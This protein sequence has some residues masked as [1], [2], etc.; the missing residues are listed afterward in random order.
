M[1]QYFNKYG[2]CFEDRQYKDK[3]STKMLNSPT[4]L[5]GKKH[6]PTNKCS[7]L[8]LI[9][10]SKLYGEKRPDRLNSRE[11]QKQDPSTVS[12][13]GSGQF[14]N[15]D[16]VLGYGPRFQ[17]GSRCRFRSL[18]RKVG[19]NPYPTVSDQDTKHES[20]HLER[21]H[22]SNAKSQFP[23]QKTI[24]ILFFLTVYYHTASNT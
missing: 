5:Y 16:T 18:I 23:R 17:Y 2:S 8:L 1:K 15:Q 21:Y 24:R 19:S 7:T 6:I 11:F 9:P 14:L 4:C 13:L 12:G 10:L 3:K 22:K 20:G